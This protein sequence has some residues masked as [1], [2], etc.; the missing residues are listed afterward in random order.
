VDAHSYLPDDILAKVDI[1]GMGNA[2]ETRAPF[3][4]HQLLEFAAACPASL[5][6]HGGTGKYLVKKALEPHLP[7]EVLTRRKMGFG[8]PV[9]EWVR[10]ELGA[11]AAD[12][13]LSPRALQRGYFRRE[14]LEAI[15]VE[16][17]TRAIDHGYRLWVLLFLELWFREYADG[18]QPLA[19]SGN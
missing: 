11:M 15:F 12:L 9:A 14:A 5:K 10:G 1:A 16:H 19:A 18:A 3:L 2:L 17:R 8:M 4:D 13:L 6:L 7:R